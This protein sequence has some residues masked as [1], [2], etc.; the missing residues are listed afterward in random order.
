[1]LAYIFASVALAASAVSFF[2]LFFYVR[3][4]TAIDRI[5]AETREQVDMIL[6]DLGKKVVEHLDLIEDGSQRLHKTKD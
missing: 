6:D 5:P 2:V 1:M 4:R 3:K